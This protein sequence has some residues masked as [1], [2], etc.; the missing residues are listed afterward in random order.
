MSVEQQEKLCN[1]LETI[2]EFT[3]LGGSRESF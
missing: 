1:K 3:Y 2:K